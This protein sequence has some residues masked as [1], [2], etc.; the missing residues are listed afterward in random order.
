MVFALSVGQLQAQSPASRT[1]IGLGE[2]PLQVVIDFGQS[3]QTRR[4]SHHGVVD[5]LGVP[6]NQQVSVTL[7][8]LR[9][10]AGEQI[11]LSS[12]DAGVVTL[13][14]PA[15]ISPDGSVV[16]GFNAGSTTGLRRFHIF[17]SAEYDLS[18]YAFDPRNPPGRRK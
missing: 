11:A 5:P 3:K 16:F 17:G 10:R 13:R 14:Q 6:I 2:D 9:K 7:K 12:L 4:E 18:L 15:T 1:G 8:F